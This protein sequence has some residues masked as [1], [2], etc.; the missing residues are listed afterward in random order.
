M[1]GLSPAQQVLRPSL[2]FAGGSGASAAGVSV[3]VASSS[4]SSLLPSFVDNDAAP[5]STSRVWN[6]GLDLPPS[7]SDSASTSFAD[8]ASANAHHR[9]TSFSRTGSFPMMSSAVSATATYDFVDDDDNEDDV[10]RR[11]RY[12]FSRIATASRRE[13]ELA[14]P[15]GTSRE[16]VDTADRSADDSGS[17]STDIRAFEGQLIYNPDGTLHVVEDQSTADEVECYKDAIIERRDGTVVGQSMP[18]YPQLTRICVRRRAASG[19]ETDRDCSTVI[20][21]TVDCPPNRAESA[22]IIQRESFVMCFICRLSFVTARSLVAHCRCRHAI[23]LDESAASVDGV[24]AVLYGVG[25]DRT[26]VLSFLEPTATTAMPSGSSTESRSPLRRDDNRSDSN[27]SLSAAKEMSVS[28]SCCP[29]PAVQLEQVTS[30]HR[31]RS[32]PDPSSRSLTTTDDDDPSTSSSRRQWRSADVDESCD[33]DADLATSVA[34]HWRRLNGAIVPASQSEKTSSCVDDVDGDSRTSARC[35]SSSNLADREKNETALDD[36]VLPSPS[37]S[38]SSNQHQPIYMPS[39]V[40]GRPSALPPRRDS[41]PHHQDELPETPPTRFDVPVGCTFGAPTPPSMMSR[42]SCKTLKCPKCNWH[43]KYQETLE[44]HMREKHPDGDATCVYCAGGGPHPRL[45]RGESYTCGYKPYRCDV[46]N[47]STTTKGNLSIHLQSDKHTNNVQELQNGSVP[48]PGGSGVAAAV[49]SATPTATQDPSKLTAPGVSAV[50]TAGSGTGA[51]RP[52]AAGGGYKMPKPSWR[53]DFCGYET[54]EARNLRI[55]MTSEKHA[56]NLLALQQSAAAV[57]MH[58]QMALYGP[59]TAAALLGLGSAAS[60]AAAFDPVAFMAGFLPQQP[61]A[62]STQPGLLPGPDAPMDLTK[63]ADDGRLSRLGDGEAT[64]L[65]GC[66]VCGVFGTDSLD[67]LQAHIQLDRSSKQLN[68][69]EQPP[70][71]A[72]VSGGTYLCTLCQYR[73]SLKANFQLHCKTDKHLQRLQLINH[74]Q[75]GG[76]GW[77][78]PL[79][80]S[81]VDVWCTAC[82]YRTNSVYRLQMHAAGAVHGARAALFRYLCALE[83]RSGLRSRRYRCAAC[84]VTLRTRFAVL[85]HSQSQQH[86]HNEAMMLGR[87]TSSG[88]DVDVR[89][90]GSVFVVEPLDDNDTVSGQSQSRFRFIRTRSISLL[91]VVCGV[92]CGVKMDESF[93]FLLLLSSNHCRRS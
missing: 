71:V 34:D 73:T 87:T 50:P 16:D 77:D 48:I 43:Y 6:A 42:N 88:P 69:G 72:V 11:R 1:A 30:A 2:C 76:G 13:S 27:M 57:N 36:P 91:F 68:G 26:P 60:P 56:H 46:C 70:G 5:T 59:E 65:F 38:S 7:C 17:K 90:L 39:S 20:Y 33:G 29:L 40:F 28:D 85:E 18:S 15:S 23:E 35:L 25:T 83:A 10:D 51:C 4:R 92:F 78:R 82:D 81:A 44:I 74:V 93:F 8:V 19:T 47:Y 58:H 84:G 62:A 9:L 54:T 24:S 67:A 14:P 52:T 75:E 55:H 63:A 61:G 3:S 22:D 41:P 45:A 53:C 32:P 86:G 12:V 64:T 37:T 89:L 49:A 21:R 66:A 80:A 31:S 79:P